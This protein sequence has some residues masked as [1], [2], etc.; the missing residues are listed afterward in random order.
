MN[1]VFAYT[2]MALHFAEVQRPNF[3]PGYLVSIVFQNIPVHTLGLE[4]F[5]TPKCPTWQTV[6]GSK[7]TR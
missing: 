1:H 7:L 6:W 5:E 4:E 2:P 3:T